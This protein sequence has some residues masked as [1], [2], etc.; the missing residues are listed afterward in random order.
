MVF[1]QEM[2]IFL[3]DGFFAKSSQKTSVFDI[4][5]RKECFIDKKSQ[6]LKKSKKSSQERTFFDIWNRKKSLLDEKSQVLKK[7]K[8]SKFS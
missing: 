1:G 7:S 3:N 5:D 2:A 6:L 4:L 8:K